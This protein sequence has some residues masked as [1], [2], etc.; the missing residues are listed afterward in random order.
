MDIQLAD[1]RIFVLTETLTFEQ[2]RQ[3][4]MDRRTNAVASGLGSLIQRPRTEDVALVASQK[5]FE[6]FWH[7]ACTA[8]YVYDRARKYNVP[9]SG[10]EVWEITLHGERYAVADMGKAGHAFNL[11]VTEHCREESR[12][13]LFADG[14]TGEAIADAASLVR[15]PKAEI[16]D[17]Q[18]LS[19]ENAI[20][21]PP[22]M[23]ASF[24]VRQLL[25]QMLKPVQADVVHEESLVLEATDLYYRP[26][27]AFEFHWKPKD[28]RGVVEFDAV[29]GQMRTSQSLAPQ[30]GKIITRDAL[31][32]LGADT[33]GMLVPGANLAVKIAKVALDAKK[34]H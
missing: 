10:P 34:Q 19:A 30:L 4:A 18:T 26:V 15:S 13:E 17:P 1:Q 6:P 29:T 20:V 23:R 28:K 16:S 27:W 3:R 31:F 24:V 2:I 11:M 7:V 9:A 32:D 5:R 33:V 8:R 21:V 14:Q 22:E 12:Q 25:N